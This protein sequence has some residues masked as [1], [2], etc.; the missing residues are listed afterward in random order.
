MNKPSIGY[1]FLYAYVHWMYR[2]CYCRHYE[3]MGIDNVPKRGATLFVTNHQNN[4]PDALS[5]L[6]ASSRKP[7]FVARADFFD[8][9]TAN[10]MLRFMRILPMYRA[11]HGKTAITENLPTTMKE[12]SDHLMAGGACVIM[13]EGSSAPA[14][15]LRPLK[16][17]WA[18]LAYSLKKQSIPI[19]VIPAVMEYNDWQDWGPD[20]RVTFGEPL[21]I[22]LLDEL[23][24]GQQLRSMKER[25][26]EKLKEM[27]R[28]DREIAEWSQETSRKKRKSTW[29]WRA[30]SY[31]FIPITFLLMWPVLLITVNR[32]KSHSRIDFK[33]TLELG[34]IGLG[35]PFWIV[36]LSLISALVLTWKIGLLVLVIGPIFLW[37]ASRS[38]IAKT[39]D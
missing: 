6:F 12:L 5:I 24:E 15:S 11:D 33:S 36:L 38:Y 39:R 29:I 9:P 2:K 25:A 35:T 13:A 26:E 19:H 27:I 1:R 31:V 20:V 23:N 7:V 21:D 34:F 18:R 22:N 32:V 30:L 28:G 10:R 17:S 3:V 8:N 16:K 14:R 37:A 4:L